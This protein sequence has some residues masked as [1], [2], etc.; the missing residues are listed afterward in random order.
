MAEA[1]L[2]LPVSHAW[3]LWRH[4]G[5]PTA[6]WFPG[7]HVTC[8][9]RGHVVAG[10]ESHLRAVGVTDDAPARVVSIVPSPTPATAEAS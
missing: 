9:E 8:F 4:W 10:I 2:R 1:V 7:G 5:R 3:A 6:I